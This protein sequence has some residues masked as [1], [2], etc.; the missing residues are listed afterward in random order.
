MAA[1]LGVAIFGLSASSSWA[2]NAH[3]PYLAHPDARYRIVAVCNSSLE[4]AQKAID[5][6][7][8]DGATPYGDPAAMAQD[9]SVDIV[10]CSDDD[11][12]IRSG[13]PVLTLPHPL[14]H[15]RA[16]VL[17]PW[18]AVDPGAE[19]GV[20]EGH[21]PVRELVDELSPAERAGVRP[22]ALSL[23]GAL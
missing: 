1:K 23:A 4:S 15:Q 5:A 20:G 2:V 21:R 8:L 6:H 3:L 13:D 11:G 14:A 9:L 7:K 19:L 16:F 10:V 17:L 22:T 18:L 12:E